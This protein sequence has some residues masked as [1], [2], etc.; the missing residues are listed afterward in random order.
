MFGQYTEEMRMNSFREMINDVISDRL[1]EMEGLTFY[2]SDLSSEIT[3][4]D[5]VNG[6]MFVYTQDARDFINDH[7]EQAAETYDYFNSMGIDINPYEN[8]DAYSFY[9]E[10]YG[11]DQVL[12]ES[13]Y[14]QQHRN[15]EITLT[16]DVINQIKD[17][18][19]IEHD[20]TPEIE[21]LYGY[22][23]DDNGMHGDPIL[24]EADPGN[25]SLFIMNNQDHQTVITDS[26]DGFVVSS[27]PGGFLDQVS[28]METR[29]K[30]LEHLLPYQQGEKFPMAFPVE[31]TYVQIGDKTINVQFNSDRDFD[32]TVFN[33]DLSEFDGGIID[34]TRHLDSLPLS[35]F[36]T[37]KDMHH[38]GGEISISEIYSLEY[39]EAVNR[40]ESLRLK[41][42]VIDDFKN[43]E[44]WQSTNGGELYR[45]SQEQ[46]LRILQFEEKYNCSVYHVIHDD[47]VMTDGTHM[48]MENYLYVS[49]SLSEWKEDREILKEG[50]TY[51]YVN[52]LTYPEFSELGEIGVA[53]RDGGLIRNDRGYDFSIMS[54]HD[55]AD[56]IDQYNLHRD[57]LSYVETEY[58]QSKNFD[59]TISA[60]IRNDFGKI[61]DDL[62]AEINSNGPMSDQAK[63]ILS[64]ID[65]Y[66]KDYSM[67][68]DDGMDLKGGMS[69]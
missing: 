29:E 10:S 65:A 31:E 64:D 44:I 23:Y 62:H 5:N 8:P 52:N 59:E 15:E 56:K 41:E 67:H 26:M 34:N 47:Y 48:E 53:P 11:V 28:D 20:K 3:M 12:N 39:D 63:E 18:L 58:Y 55:L 2:G 14:L 51:S 7:P 13:L 36:E 60:V 61:V 33:K 21:T 49:D 40:M 35:I 27:L 38:L 68:M 24:F 25:I 1:D 37:I 43:G 6:T 42:D 50:L 32:Y 22:V 46:D 45:L 54:A 4:E 66:S 69:L 57:P 19:G 16:R 17:D 30:I 9:M